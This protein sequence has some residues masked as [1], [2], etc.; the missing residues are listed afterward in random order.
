MTGPE[1]SAEHGIEARTG[2]DVTLPWQPRDEPEMMSS[3]RKCDHGNRD[4]PEMEKKSRD[5]VMDRFKQNF[6]GFFTCLVVAEHYSCPCRRDLL[7]C[8]RRDTTGRSRDRRRVCRRR[9]CIAWFL[10]R[11]L[12]AWC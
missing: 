4:E 7:G 12:T 2:N 11:F 9:L 1:S 6:N 10:G 8:S 5:T 3:N